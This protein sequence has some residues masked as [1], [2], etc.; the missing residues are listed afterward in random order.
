M[1][2]LWIPIVLC[3]CGTLQ[4]QTPA[5]LQKQITQLQALCAQMVKNEQGLQAQLSALQRSPVQA[6]A[7]FVTVD[8][9]PEYG[10]RGP[11]VIFHD[12]NLHLTNGSFN[13]QTSNGLGNLII[14]Y[15]VLDP[16]SLLGPIVRGGSHNLIIGDSHRFK[17]GATSC[18][19][20]G[21]FNEVDGPNSAA[22]AGGAH[23]VWGSNAAAI[24]GWNSLVNSDYSVA[25]G[26]QGNYIAD[27]DFFVLV[28]GR[29]AA[30]ISTP[31]LGEFGAIS[32]Q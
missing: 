5:Q 9:N 10:V 31:F 16:T 3:L 7:S 1:K 28:G 20:S 18:I 24:G 27:A 2:R 22:I 23:R 14:G 26:G 12:C 25:L 13:T 8:P 15:D 6:L 21:T 11:N 17:T 30:S 29:S 32:G 4:A 19:V